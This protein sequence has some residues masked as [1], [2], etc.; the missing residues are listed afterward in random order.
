M[1][2][3]SRI[4]ADTSGGGSGTYAGGAFHG[5]RRDDEGKLYYNKAVLSQRGVTVNLTDGSVFDDADD[6]GYGGRN[7][8]ARKTGETYE[9]WVIDSDQMVFYINDDGFLVVR[10]NEPYTYTGPN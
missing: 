5:F 10:L 2:S 8:V 9:Q 7:D 1:P 4:K 6:A 3:R